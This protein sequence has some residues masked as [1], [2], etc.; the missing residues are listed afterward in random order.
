MEIDAQIHVEVKRV[1]RF[2]LYD[3]LD[4]ARSEAPAEKVP[5]VLHRQNRKDWVVCVRLSDLRRLVAEVAAAGA[6][7]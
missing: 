1:E 2:H 7:F 4:Q 6:V 5:I 3:A